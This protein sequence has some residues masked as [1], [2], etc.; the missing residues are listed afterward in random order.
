MSAVKLVMFSDFDLE[1]FLPIARKALGRGITSQ[2]AL[3]AELSNMLSI[4]GLIDGD[5]NDVESFYSL[6]YLIAADYRDMPHIIQIASMPHITT[7]SVARDIQ[8]AVIAGPLSDWIK[9]VQKGCSSNVGT[10]VRKTYNIIYKDLDSRS[11]CDI[12]KVRTRPQEDS[13]FLLEH[14]K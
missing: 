6:A 12:L 4:A 14:K 3:S 9:A 11:L 5:A 7:S 1:A 8:V 10:E 2:T 13:T